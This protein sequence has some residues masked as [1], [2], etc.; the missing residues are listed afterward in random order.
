[1]Y[2]INS[3]GGSI[4]RV[5]GY[6]SIGHGINTNDHIIHET[7]SRR[8]SLGNDFNRRDGIGPIGLLT[9]LKDIIGKGLSI[10]VVIHQLG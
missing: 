10:G 9:R 8:H 5:F 7:I 3:I 1:M 6:W 2:Y 4:G